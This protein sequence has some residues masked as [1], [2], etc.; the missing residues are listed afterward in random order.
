MESLPR[1]SVVTPCFRHAHYLDET[2][3]SVLGQGYPDLEYFV[4]DGGSDD[5][6]DGILRRWSDRITRWTSEPDR[7]AADAIEKGFGWATGEILAWLNASD[8]YLPGALRAVGSFFSRHPDVD[9]ICGDAVVTDASG[10]RLGDRRILPLHGSLA[11]QGLTTLPQ[12]AVFWRRRLH[13]RTGGFDPELRY[14]FDLD[15]FGRMARVG[16]FAH[17]P[18][19]LAR[20]RIHADSLRARHGDRDREEREE[21]ARRYGRG[22]PGPA[23]RTLARAAAFLRAGRFWDGLR[24]LSQSAVARGGLAGPPAR[25][26]G[27]ILGLGSGRRLPGS[28]S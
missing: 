16:R 3:R 13:R 15:L 9:W 26:M 8:A 18:R 25:V 19:V 10:R 5:G 17:L 1:I 4:V 24:D 7:G 28:T 21:V 14:Y 20:D 2:I 23:R 12:P 6:S 11:A 22:N 27:L